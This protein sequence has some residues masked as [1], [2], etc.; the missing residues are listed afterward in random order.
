[1]NN[2]KAGLGI[3]I[4]TRG[5]VSIKWMT[6]MEKL[7]RFFPIGMFWKY[8]IVE[9]TD[10]W[11]INRNEV[12]RRAQKENFE[13]LLWID[14]DVFIPQDAARR[15][16][17]SGK[18]IMTG[19]YWTKTEHE[20]P[21]I[22]EKEGAGPMYKFPIDKQFQVAGSG[23]GCCLVNM[24]VFDAFDKAGIPY[25]KENWVMETDDGKK[26]K[27]PIGEDHYF[28]WNAKRLGFD[29][30]ADSGLLCDH[31]DMNTK[32][33][34]PSQETVRKITGNKLK[35]IGREDIVKEHNKQLGLNP[36]KKTIVILNQTPN[37]FSGDELE[38]RGVGG[39]ET[40]I[41][42]LARTLTLNFNVHVFCTCSNPG[43]Y[44]N[45]I[46]HNLDSDIK[47]LKGLNTDLLIVSRNTD[48]RDYKKDYNAKQVV[49]WAHDVPE[50]PS[51]KFI[52]QSHTQ[53][54]KIVALTNNHREEI[55]KTFPFI[56]SDKVIVIGHGIDTGRFKDKTIK[57]VPGRM[58]YSST[59]FR[60][61]EVLAKVFPKIK[62]RVPNA[63]LK[64]F[65][66]MKL[67]GPSYNDDEFITLYDKLK[68]I[69]GI[70]YHESIKQDELAKEFMKAEVLTYPNSFPETFCITAIE[71]IASGTPIVTSNYAGLKDTITDDVG[72]KIDGN[73]FSEEYQNKFIDSVVELLTNKD[74][75]N[76]IN[77]SC[78]SKDVSWKT[79]AKKWI[80]C[81]FSDPD[82]IK[83]V[84]NINT[85]EYWDKVYEYEI[86]QNHVR[87]DTE[88]LNL[89]TKEFNGG[90]LLD[91]GCGTGELT[92][93]FRKEF[94]NAEI[95]GCDFS[96]K[97]I[98]Y[99]RQHN[100]TIYYANH[101]LLNKDYEKK[102]FDMITIMHVL[103]HLEKP[104]E[105]I[106]RAKELLK[107]DGTLIIALPLNDNPWREHLKVWK[108][109]DIAE[110]L[111]K[112]KCEYTFHRTLS[113]TRKYP[114]GRPFEEA[115]V[116][117][118][119]INEV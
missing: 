75:W 72:I 100:K 66:S 102:Y 81:F 62:E 1:M 89:I 49:L 88:Q 19:I 79:S 104:E 33:F 14:D 90:N 109:G 99:C 29:T 71:G 98:D 6:H 57:K 107:D 56:N 55:L 95:W 60:G 116:I 46:Y 13:Y 91:V 59:P 48:V 16:V 38:K 78:L 111:E 82:S 40:C 70:E 96:N 35:K 26:M 12:V 43:I 97:A 67:Y 115:I 77:E 4:I 7:K 92:R 51:F 119:F 65:S 93:T 45:V 42:N 53:F 94:P 85:Q 106:K 25:F 114:D 47:Q 101:P 80:E 117:I 5:T 31:Y 20:A 11:A 50:D 83:Q 76:K 69:D 21:V 22:F 28:F 10:G 103:E 108:L 54:D 34:F 87:K 112:F 36:D 8:I 3:G 110:L 58:I 24:K 84:G 17:A 27:C 86:S 9:G 113:K 105:L 52:E 39:A 74:K 32:T 61:L 118:K 64:V 18:D 44:D 68:K 2:K 63:S 15:M 73:P 30:W 23:L 41:I 37:A